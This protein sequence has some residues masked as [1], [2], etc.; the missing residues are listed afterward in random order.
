[1]GKDSAAV[2]TTFAYLAVMPKFASPPVTLKLM[3]ENIRNATTTLPSTPSTACVTS[4][5]PPLKHSRCNVLLL[6]PM[7]RGFR[8][9]CASVSSHTQPNEACCTTPR[10]PFSM[11][12]CAKLLCASTGVARC[13]LSSHARCLFATARPPSIR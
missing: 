13:D 8:R 3:E 10:H 9:P 7:F 12:P 5:D 4:R 2:S 1:M 11:L 6:N